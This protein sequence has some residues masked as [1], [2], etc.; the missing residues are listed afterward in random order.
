VTQTATACGQSTG[1]ATALISGGATPYALTQWSSG[2]QNTTSVN[3]LGAGQYS[4]LV[5]DANTCS[6]TEFFDI[7]STTATATGTVT[8]VDCHGAATGGIAITTSGLTAPITALWS[9]GH[10]T[11]SLAQVP[12]GNY[13]VNLW[14]ANGCA[15][16]KTFTITEPDVLV[17]DA[18]AIFPTCQQADG[19]M[20]VDQTTGGTGAYSYAWSNGATGTTASNIPFGIYS[21]TTTDGNNCTAIN[22]LY[23][24][25]QG[26]ADLYGSVTPT[27]CG[28]NDGAINVSPN[29]PAGETVTSILWS[30]GAV[31][32][33]ILN[34]VPATY[35][36][37]LVTSNNCTAVKG[38]DIPAVEPLRNDICVVTVDSATTTNLVVWERVQTTGIAYYKIYRES[39]VQGVFALIDTVEAT[40]LSL[41]NDVVAS[42]LTRS[43]RY[44]ISAVNT[45]GLEGPLSAAHQTIHLDV[46]DNG[47]DVTI[48]WNA[49]IGAAFSTYT[50]SRYTDLNGWE[51]V[52]TVPATQLTYTDNMPYTTS[53]LDY[54]VEINLDQ[55]CT[56]VV[57]RAQ[58]FNSSRSNKD[59]GQFAAGNGTG[60]SN[61]GLDEHYL[62]TVQV[63]PNPTNGLLN[64]LQTESRAVEIQVRSLD[65]Q[66]MQTHTVASLHDQLDLGAYA[67]GMYF[68][69]L[70]MNQTQQTLRIIK[71]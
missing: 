29:A 52:A 27:T 71:H 68:I 58:D 24:S 28:G 40:N 48:N 4:F 47:S 64:I 30:N 3:N 54:M 10:S 67:S 21:L 56:A 22:T 65:G 5:T 6:V 23:V 57:W 55:T 43:W 61:N 14:D 25:E 11:I 50:V 35:T 44:K 7:T 66:L 26:S 36:C 39:A 69:T 2:P 53:G 59:K 62:S 8:N 1:T 9:S 41:F 31:T 17:S 18:S 13:T 45:C 16:T 15:V 38:W 60:D 20:Q 34:L 37:T 32:E 33:D 70:R 12:A 49:Y 51:V 63:S 19:S 46:L 42:P